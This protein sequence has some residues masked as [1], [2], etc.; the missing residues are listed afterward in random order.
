M[1]EP[2]SEDL[3]RL[4][5]SI[6]ALKQTQVTRQEFEALSALV[7]SLAKKID[8]IVVG[9]GIPDEDLAIMSAAFA[10]TIGKRFKV[11]SIKVANQPSGWAQ[12]GRVNLHAQ[13]HVRR[14]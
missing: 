3:R 10:A 9:N 7:Q 14:S 13:R 8:Q 4:T 2:T 6:D 5:Q 1:N 12:A 11:K